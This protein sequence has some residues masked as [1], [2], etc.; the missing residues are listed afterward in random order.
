MNILIDATQIPR[1]KG[2][3][4][5]YA[6]GLVRALAASVSPHKLTVLVQSDEHDFEGIESTRV[7]LIKVPAKIFRRLFFRFVLEQLV[8]PFL[9]FWKRIDVIHSLHYSF[10]LC[11]GRTKKVVTVHDLTFFRFP[12]LHTFCKRHY[13]K[14]FTKLAARLADRVVAV[15]ENTRSDFILLTGA[16]P[17]KTCTVHLGRP[18]FAD[19]WFQEHI[20]EATRKRYGIDGDYLLFVG[21]LEP[22][23]NLQNLVRAYAAL[24][25]EGLSHPLVIVGAEGWDCGAFFALI[26]K[27]GVHRHVVFTGYVDD[28]TKYHLLRGAVLFVYPSIYEGFGL[29]VLEALSLGV[30]TITGTAPALR[31]VSGDAALQV[32][33]YDVGALSRSMKRLLEDASLRQALSA[34]AFR[35]SKDFSWKKAAE[36]TESVYVAAFRD[37]P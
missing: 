33:P 26:R 20:L 13:F 6:V 7:R 32:D 27:L 1:K 10:P 4:G 25:N 14:L 5:V 11:T 22:R 23:K 3:V 28:R 8:V 31:E 30:P 9:L 29:P 24:L 34:K 12:Q 35:R 2:G 18:E 17:R 16:K 19:C 21:T 15:S 36:E 37:N